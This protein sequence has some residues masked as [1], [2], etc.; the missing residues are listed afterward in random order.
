M[1]DLLQIIPSVIGGGFIGSIATHYLTTGRERREIRSTAMHKLGDVEQIRWAGDYSRK[2]FRIALRE[3]ETAALIAQL[4]RDLVL[5][6]KL[7]AETARTLSENDLEEN[8]GQDEDY[9]GGID[10]MFAAIVRD[11]AATMSRAIWSPIITR[12]TL[13]GT[14][15]TLENR[16]IDIETTGEKSLLAVLTDFS[17]YRWHV[18]F[19]AGKEL[20]RRR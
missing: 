19:E 16:A 3:L 12:A 17:D 13:R 18:K 5:L 11:T 9:A 8:H 1:S 6:Y 2:E 15:K 7:L 10:G 14:I 20:P 4:P